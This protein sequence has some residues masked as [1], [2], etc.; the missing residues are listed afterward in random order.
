MNSSKEPYSDNGIFLLQSKLYAKEKVKLIYKGLL[1][2]S[3]ADRVY[4]YTGYGEEWAEEEYIE[5]EP[6]QDGFTANIVAKVPGILN[7][8][9]KDS[10]NNWDNNSGQNYTFQVMSKKVS[11]KVKIVEPEI[12]EPKIKESKIKES[13]V[14]TSRSKISRGKVDAHA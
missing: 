1:V 13:K 3:G 7:I 2:E 12:N 5:M 4:V 11:G 14:K 9:F 10:A 8:C 6:A